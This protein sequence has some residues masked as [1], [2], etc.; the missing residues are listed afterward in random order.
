M[1][2]LLWLKALSSIE[3]VHNNSLQSAVICLVIMTAGISM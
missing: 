2:T 3:E 1:S